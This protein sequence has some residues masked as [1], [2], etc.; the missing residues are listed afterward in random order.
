MSK[1]FQLTI[2]ATSIGLLVGWYAFSNLEGASFAYYQSLE[3]F[4]A[5][6][7]AQ[8]GVPA[9]VHGYV[10]LK[11]IERDI[12]AKQVHFAVQN[13]PPHSGAE[14]PHPASGDHTGP[15]RG[16]GSVGV[17]HGRSRD[18]APARRAPPRR[19]LNRSRTRLPAG[20][21]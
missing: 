8:R 20:R 6:P 13:A 5:S 17:D 3:T 21:G 2:G 15:E 1:G 19:G 10:T 11:S 12:G 18:G 16:D 14:H 9:R 7:E 4:L